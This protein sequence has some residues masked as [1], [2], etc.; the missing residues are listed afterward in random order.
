MKMRRPNAS[1]ARVKNGTMNNAK[2]S[3]VKVFTPEAHAYVVTAALHTHDSGMLS[4]QLAVL[5]PAHVAPANQS[6]VMNDI[7]ADRNP[8]LNDKR[9][10]QE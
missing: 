1:L 7:L 3:D 9:N 5:T 4:S 8:L 2:P 10:A 6:T